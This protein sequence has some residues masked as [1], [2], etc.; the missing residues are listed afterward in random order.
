[1]REQIDS[2]KVANTEILSILKNL[3]YEYLSKIPIEYIRFLIDNSLEDEDKEYT[4]FDENGNIKVSSIGE[5]IL[6]YLNLEY[7][8]T[9]EEKNEL[10]EIYEKN[11]K[12]I[13][14][15]YNANDL[16]KNKKKINTFQNEEKSLI[17]IQKKSVIFTIFEKIKQWLGI[18][19]GM[20][21]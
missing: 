20:K 5:E 1:M 21:K 16:F 3:S 13:N 11:E 19:K 2:Y 4:G 9:E 8:V 12:Y 6:D 18:I 10:I 15:K 7:W 14:E 17:V